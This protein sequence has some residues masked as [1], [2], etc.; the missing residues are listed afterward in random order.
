MQ[1]IDLTGQIFERL[2][3]IERN[4]ALN[5][6]VSW[7]CR[8][9]CGNELVVRSRA[10]RGGATKSC[11]CLNQERRRERK[12]VHGMSD[13]PEG[14]AWRHMMQRC[15]KPKTQNFHRYGGR[16][17]SVCDLWH[18][19]EH[20]Y[21]DM[22]PRPSPDHTLERE[23]NDRGYEPG[24]CV[25]ATRDKQYSNRSTNHRLTHNGKTLTVTE[26]ATKLGFQPMTIFSRL[27][28]GWSVERALTTPLIPMAERR[29]PR[30]AA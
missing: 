1:A 18:S 13:A 2:T 10:L 23:D 25:W 20:F 9:D 28:S 30:P 14:V 6:S 3:V 4:G 5:G 8:C 15:G 7:R 27:K 11:G 17:I 29:W 12:T 19:F 21:A 16:G 26:W 22:G 24:N